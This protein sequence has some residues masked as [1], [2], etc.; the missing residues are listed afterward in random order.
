VV[1]RAALVVVNGWNGCKSGWA[2]QSMVNEWGE[3]DY[4][5]EMEVDEVEDIDEL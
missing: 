3:G 2:P 1:H 5:V 4:E